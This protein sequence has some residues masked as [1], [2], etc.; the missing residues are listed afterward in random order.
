[1]P[2]FLAVP[3]EPAIEMTAALRDLGAGGV[4]CYTAGFGEI[5][6]SDAEARLV[7]AA[8][9]MALVGANCYGLINYVDKV[10]LWPFAHGGFYP[11]FGAAVITQSGML[12]SDLTMNRR[13]VPLAYMISAGNQSVLRLEDYISVL[14]SDPAVRAIGPAHRG[15]EGRERVRG[16]LTRGGPRRQTRG[17][18]KDGIVAYRQPADGQPHRLASRHRRACSMR[19]SSASASSASPARHSC[20]RTLKFLCV[21]G[22][23]KGRRI[24]GLTCSGG[25]ATMLADHGEKIDLDFPQPETGTYER[26]RTLLPETATVSNPL[27][28][29]TPIWGMPGKTEPVFRA[30]VGA[31]H[32]AAIMVQDYPAPVSRTPSFLIATMPQLR[33]R[34]D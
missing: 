26:L 9:D 21:A 14:A 5:G 3:R 16:G 25:G 32:D 15:F 31:G 29:T 33:C 28:Y 10:A 20:W 19:C 2:S 34:H 1:M 7:E 30:F 27:D 6:K 17:G 12:S 4:V 24:A 13:S 23:P 8:G 18:A 22:V 11:G